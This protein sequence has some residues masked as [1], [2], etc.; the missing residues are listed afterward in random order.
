[1]A[2][3]VLLL[4]ILI[5][6]NGLTPVFSYAVPE[7]IIEIYNPKGLRVSIPH[8]VGIELFAFHGN[9]NEPMV[10]QRAGQ[11]SKN[12]MERIG[13]WWV[14]EDRDVVLK[15]GDRIYYRMFIVRSGLGYRRDNGMYVVRGTWKLHF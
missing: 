12:V 13:D 11:I 5:Y 10:N 1:M 14:V 3:I 8:D 6:L 15:P 2:A 7:P 9:I 4:L